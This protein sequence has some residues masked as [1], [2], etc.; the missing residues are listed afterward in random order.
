VTT[1]RF[2]ATLGLANQAINSLNISGAAECAMLRS[3]SEVP[4]AVVITT[5]LIGSPAF[6]QVVA[7]P[8]VGSSD[9]SMHMPKPAD[10]VPDRVRTYDPEVT[11]GI[12]VRS[13]LADKP[14]NRTGPPKS[15]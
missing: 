8:P 15:Q 9:A 5:V 14:E 3:F 12:K 2:G 13:D 4:L 7:E 11:G 6:A 10:V 1:P